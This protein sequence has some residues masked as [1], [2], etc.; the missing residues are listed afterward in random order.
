MPTNIPLP[1][2]NNS[3]EPKPD[4]PGSIRPER[5]RLRE[6]RFIACLFLL[7]LAA[8]HGPLY[9]PL[10]TLLIAAA[11]GQKGGFKR[12]WQIM[13]WACAVG[14]LISSLL[15]VANLPAY[16]RGNVL[17]WIAAG[18]VMWLIPRIFGWDEEGRV[19]KIG[20]AL[21]WVFGALAGVE[22]QAFIAAKEFE[23]WQS[24]TPLSEQGMWREAGMPS[25]E[26][27]LTRF[28]IFCVA[29]TI[30]HLFVRMRK[31]GNQ[32]PF[33]YLGQE[34]KEQQQLSDRPEA[35]TPTSLATSTSARPA[36]ISAEIMTTSGDSMSIRTGPTSPPESREPA[37]SSTNAVTL[38]KPQLKEQELTPKPVPKFLKY[39]VIGVGLVVA[40][41]IAFFV[42]WLSR[43]R[44]PSAGKDAA[45][46]LNP[47]SQSVPLTA[48]PD[49]AGRQVN[50]HPIASTGFWLGEPG[51]PFFDSLALAS[52]ASSL[53]SGYI[54]I[55][56][57]RRLIWLLQ[58]TP[59]VSTP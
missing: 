27:L 45:K 16:I 6:A 9:L 55:R 37:K 49:T 23:H 5:Q 20:H 36:P 21:A 3:T 15:V 14:V 18:I 48:A 13:C 32:L 40:L 51:N 42:I 53:R 24:V 11:T 33:R 29:A 10:W 1:T 26:F 19:N 35:Q 39:G 56:T 43:G 25:T 54:S 31:R 28:I 44:M 30:A 8:F 17:D 59:N 46:H 41:V 38:D 50:F 58:M 52:T 12:L 22:L 2:C 4:S 7:L 47:N 57:A 34:I